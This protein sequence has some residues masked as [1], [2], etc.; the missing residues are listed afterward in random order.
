MPSTTTSA[1]GYCLFGAGGLTIDVRVVVDASSKTVAIRSAPDEKLII[2]RNC[3][4]RVKKVLQ[5]NSAEAD[6]P[7]IER[8]GYANEQ[9][10]L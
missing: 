4:S 3:E 8:C 5:P 9:G 1:P 2:L 10:M 7:E 6:E